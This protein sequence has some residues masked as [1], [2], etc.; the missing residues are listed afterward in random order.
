MDFL[1]TG[2]A[3][4]LATVARDNSSVLPFKDAI[5]KALEIDGGLP[6]MVFQEAFTQLMQRNLEYLHGRVVSN[7]PMLID[8]LDC[9][10]ANW[11]E[12]DL[13]DKSFSWRMTLI[14]QEVSGNRAVLFTDFEGKPKSSIMFFDNDSQGNAVETHL[15]NSLIPKLPS[16]AF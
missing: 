15:Y 11:G 14:T 1:R 7:L 8:K 9:F 4:E 3:S 13:S 10:E 6:G 12:R 2:L 16:M 5:L